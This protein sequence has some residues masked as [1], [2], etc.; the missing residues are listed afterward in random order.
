MKFGINIYSIS[1]KITSGEITPEKAV[2]WLSGEA[3]AEVIEI[4]PFGIDILGNA[5]LAKNLKKI[6]G[7]CGSAIGNYSLNANFLQLA[8]NEYGAEIERVKRHIDA[9]AKLGAETMRIDASSYRR[10]PEHNTIENFI[11]DLPQIAETY[12]NL[13]VF[14]KKYGLVVLLENH[15]FHING[16]DRVGAV[17][18]LVKNGNFSHQLD[19]G[20]FLCVDENP[21]IAA[22]KL[23][24]KAKAIHMKDFYVRDENSDPG[25]ATQFDCSGSWFRSQHGAYLRGSILGQGDMDMKKISKIIKDSGFDGC[26]YLEYEG[27]EDCY[28]GTKVGF[29]NM[30][31]LLANR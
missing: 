23:A 31:K 25:D 3:G 24:P 4:V 10:K 19:V 16:S 11:G 13:C 20:N 28:Y 7:D 1:R 22:K 6:A 15:G 5:G 21:E 26:A 2:S 29:E 18:S 8:Q 12:D 17:L 30:K 9:A 14:A 27:M